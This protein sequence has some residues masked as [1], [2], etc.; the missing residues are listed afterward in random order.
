MKIKFGAE[1]VVFLFG[2]VVIKIPMSVAGLVKNF[3]EFLFDFLSERHF[4]V[5]T[6]FSAGIVNVQKRVL[7][8]ELSPSRLL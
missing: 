4:V 5:P 3:S 7:D 6:Y 2:P 8:C 1:R